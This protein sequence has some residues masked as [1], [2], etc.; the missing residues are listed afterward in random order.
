MKLVFSAEIWDFV[1]ALMEA[2]SQQA[3]QA[4][5][6]SMWGQPPPAVRRAQLD[7]ISVRTGKLH[8]YPK[9]HLRDSRPSLT[10]K[11]ITTE[12]NRDAAS[13]SSKVDPIGS[14]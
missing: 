6:V 9:A 7:S 12:E 4:S 3:A 5:A 14:G 2:H 11:S 10:V 13:K 1:G 8:H